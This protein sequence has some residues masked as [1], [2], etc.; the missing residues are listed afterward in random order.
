MRLIELSRVHL[1]RVSVQV[2][3]KEAAHDYEL[4]LV[5]HHL[6]QVAILDNPS[7]YGSRITL[8]YVETFLHHDCSCQVYVW[9]FEEQL[10]AAGGLSHLE[11][12]SNG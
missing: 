1:E 3:A 11:L 4:Q 2:R 10:S 5:L 7:Y 12:S 9:S 6:I 8:A